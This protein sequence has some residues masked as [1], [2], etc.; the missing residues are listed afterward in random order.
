MTPRAGAV[1]L[2]A[3]VAAGAALR[4]AVR[5]RRRLDLRGRP[6]VVTGGSRGLGLAI[7]RELVREGCPV[8]ICARDEAELIR[9][10]ADL[11]ARGGDVLAVPADVSRPEDA[12]RLIA[13]ATLRFGRVDLLVNNA[14]VILG[15]PAASLALEDFD[16][17]M[18]VNFRGAL[19]PTLAVLPQMRARREGRIAFVTSFGGKVSVPHLVPYNCSFRT[20]RRRPTRPSAA[21]RS[22][23]AC[24][25]RRWTRS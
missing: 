5:R 7:A 10:E 9:A 16:H 23:R 19:H 11:L 20:R 18:A 14:G 2:A 21:A 24:G 17:A 13:E 25:T 22:T 3:A 8:A 4:A 6:A 1:H 12:G 15:G